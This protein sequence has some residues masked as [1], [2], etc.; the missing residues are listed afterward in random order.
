[1]NKDTSVQNNIILP[2]NQN[3]IEISFVGLSYRTAGNIIYK[4]R[5]SGINDQWT[6]TKNTLVSYPFLPDGE[7]KFEVYAMNKDGV[8]SIAPATI[9]FIINP[10]FW[11]TWWFIGVC[12]LLFAGMVRVF[13]YFRIKAVKKRNALRLKLNKYMQQALSQQMNPHFIFNSLNSIQYYILQNDRLA[14]NKY[15]SKF[16]SLMRII[17]DNSQHQ[18]IP[19]KDELNALNL[20]IELEAMRFKEKFQFSITVDEKLD[21]SINKIPP[22][23]IQPYVENAIWHGLMHKE[24]NGILEVG[25]RLKDNVIICTI[26]DNGIGRE[27]A[28][29]IKNKKIQTYKSRGTKITGDRLNLINTLNNM[30]MQINYFDLKDNSGNASGTKV[31]ITIP[32]I[33]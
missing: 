32:L 26:T 10:P 20:Y 15:L 33:H 2:Y 3:L 11:K 14:S 21:T 24:D 30:K 19:L 25:L 8:Y 13:I 6:F 23:L 17:L 1:M 18:L 5:L 31:E 4:Y 22:L 12:I 28:A 9:T 29:E 7:Y 27:K 16:A